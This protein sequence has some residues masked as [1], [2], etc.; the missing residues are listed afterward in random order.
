MLAGFAGISSSV[1]A[2]GAS[3]CYNRHVANVMK[4]EKYVERSQD[5]LLSL[6]LC[7]NHT[8][9]ARVIVICNSIL[10]T[11]RENGGKHQQMILDHIHIN[12][13]N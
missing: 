1:S 11:D 8:Q 6:P 7:A 12:K 9:M 5:Q 10:L 2:N 3:R 4:L 13:I